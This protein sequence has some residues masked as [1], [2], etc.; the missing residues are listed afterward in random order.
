MQFELTLSGDVA[1]LTSTDQ[2]QLATV[3]NETFP[4]ATSVNYTIRSGSL[5][6]VTLVYYDPSQALVAQN[7]T[8]QALVSSFTQS[9]QRYNYTRQILSV[10]VITHVTHPPGYSGSVIESVG[11]TEE[12]MLVLSAI[13][14]T[15]VAALSVSNVSEND[16]SAIVIQYAMGVVTVVILF[17]WFT[18]W[19]RRRT[20]L[21]RL[22][23]CN[24]PNC[25]ECVQSAQ[26]AL[27]SVNDIGEIE[28]PT[29]YSP[30]TDSHVVYDER[31][32]Q[33][34]LHDK[35]TLHEY[36]ADIDQYANIGWSPK[37]RPPSGRKVTE[38]QDLHSSSAGSNHASR[39]VASIDNCRAPHLTDDFHVTVDTSDDGTTD[40]KMGSV[41]RVVKYMP[42]TVTTNT[43]TTN[44]A[45][46][47][48][49]GDKENNQAEI[50]NDVDNVYMVLAKWTNPHINETS[51]TVETR[52]NDTHL[53]DQRPDHPPQPQ[54]VD[55]REF[56][57]LA[58]SKRSLPR[59]L[60]LPPP[61]PSVA[62]MDVRES[63]HDHPCHRAKNQVAKGHGISA[64]IAVRR[65]RVGDR[66]AFHTNASN[67]SSSSSSTNTSVN[68]RRAQY[69]RNPRLHSGSISN[70]NATSMTAARKSFV[71]KLSVPPHRRTHVNGKTMLPLNRFVV[72]RK[73]AGAFLRHL[74]ATQCTTTAS[75]N[76]STKLNHR[77]VLQI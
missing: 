70:M 49:K 9:M 63:T 52:H 66:M 34:Q 54:D 11:S 14:D 50:D 64:L 74:H 46:A 15:G 62:T 72:A 67:A 19:Y 61:E 69:K 38:T 40:V 47:V 29:P 58:T 7:I 71:S 41:A 26:A 21:K 6:V 32:N 76:D 31:C 27:H 16:T 2:V 43:V 22:K 8:Q 48:F 37:E 59:A 1:T 55:E 56:L 23:A 3:L 45:T 12:G 77:Q 42:N 13:N 51:E 24:K 39:L 75:M 18:C 33:L 53:S 65:S 57:A 35:E 10:S 17:G 68:P 4:F 36:R 44:T 20:R 5:V 28:L 25:N 73:D 30:S 60:P